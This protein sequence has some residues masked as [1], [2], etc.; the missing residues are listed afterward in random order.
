METF[1][2]SFWLPKD[3]NSRE[4]Y[5]DAFYPRLIGQDERTVQCFG[6]ADGASEGMF[7]G[8]WA[9]ILVNSLCSTP[10]S[11]FNASLNRAYGRWRRWRRRYLQRREREGKMPPWYEESALETG[12]F[13]TV[14]TLTLGETM[15]GN[16]HSRGTWRSTAVGDSCLFQTRAD[17]LLTRFP[18]EQS[19]QFSNRPLLVGSLPERNQSLADGIHVLEGQW[20]VD[21]HFY[22]ATDALS[23][24]LLMEYEAA[25]K[26]WA[27]LV[28]LDTEAQAESFH[29]WISHLRTNQLLKN[30]D[31]T[32]VRIDMVSGGT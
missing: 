23:R 15:G 28:D 27:M 31:V 11:T 25:R 26:P 18:L 14:L 8:R 16:G 24:W 6:I 29:G 4:E 9:N 5:E 32:L 3:G 20:E 2:Q 19:S 17:V 12:S 22:L 21:D 10:D 1:V 30:D 13:S 7:S